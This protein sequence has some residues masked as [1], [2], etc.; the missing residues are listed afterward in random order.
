M[1]ILKIAFKNINSLQGAH[2]VDFRKAPFY[3][4]T[5]FAITGATGSGKSSILDIIVLA[6]FNRTPRFGKISKSE[7]ENNGAILTRG[8]K[9]AY[10]RVTYESNHGEFVSE[11]SISTARTGN[12]RDYEMQVYDALTHTSLVQKKSEVP[13]KNEE[14]IGLKYDQFVKSV[15]LAQGEFAEFLIS[16]KSE[17]TI[18]LEKITGT[19]I[20][21]KLGMKAFEKVRDIKGELDDLE[22]EK[23]NWEKELL[24]E[25]QFNAFKEDKKVLEEK[26]KKIEEEKSHIKSLIELKNNINIAE[27]EYEA[28]LTKEKE[29]DAAFEK[30]KLNEGVKLHRHK[31]I[32]PVQNELIEWN[33]V[34]NEILNLEKQIKENEVESAKE[35]SL[36]D[37]FRYEIKSL[38][39]KSVNEDEYE[40]A[41]SEFEKNVNSLN[42]RYEQK[43]ALG[44]SLKNQISAEI[45]PLNVSFGDANYE[46]VLRKLQKL[47]KEA[48]S[49]LKNHDME[50]L[51]VEQCE[52]EIIILQE[53][54]TTLLQAKND[55]SHILN[56]QVENETLEKEKLKLEGTLIDLPQQITLLEERLKHEKALL[57]NL[58]LKLENQKL[59]ASLEEH[60]HRLKDGEACPLCG[61]IEH[62]FSI[63][64]PKENPSTLEKQISLKKQEVDK[65]NTNYNEQKTTLKLNAQT[66]EK[67]N[68]KINNLNQNLIKLKEI[69]NEK[70]AFELNTPWDEKSQLLKE[71]AEILKLALKHKKE[72]SISEIAIPT[73]EKMLTVLEEATKARKNLRQLYN[74]SL[75]I[76]EKIS[77]ME[78]NWNK[79]KSQQ[80]ILDSKKE[81]LAKDKTQQLQN[82][83]SLVSII[84]NKLSPDEFSSLEMAFSSL[85]KYDDLQRL[86]SQQ[87]KFKEC[88]QEFRIRKESILKQIEQFKLKDVSIPLEDLKAN[89]T[90]QQNLEKIEKK[91]W[92]EIQRK[93]VNQAEYKAKINKIEKRIQ[94]VRKNSQ[95]WILLNELIGDAKGNKFNTFAQDLTLLQLLRLA[96]K[97]LAMLS[98][99][100]IIDNSA[101]G[102]DESLVVIDQD[103]GGVRRTV[104]SLSGGETFILSLA[105][106]LALSDLAS[107]NVQIQSLFIDE[108][109]GTLDPD[110]LDQTLT[111]LEQLQ[112]EGSKMIGI[113]SHVSTLKERISTQ[114][115]IVPNGR[116]FSSV[117]II[118]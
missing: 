89:L 64:L 32:V 55:A 65:L 76:E 14:L 23:I 97:R 40:A 19:D 5:L 86:E 26:I 117:Q 102:E 21:R 93:L 75:P 113:I 61:A 71:K 43:K 30:F 6:L 116:G 81:S 63:H 58:L 57:E 85:L 90:Q 13:D 74:N 111:T 99:R 109:F 25:N 18:L 118:G 101:Q 52:N 68:E 114:I 77:S 95:H 2:E 59:F 82:L 15:M 50:H 47:K 51:D 38:L 53:Q 79:L 48:L 60:R 44:V 103:M 10:A 24:E 8:Q 73:T 88:Q 56:S 1:K 27:L 70:Y 104:K 17:R 36:K 110:T 42:H 37:V 41:L 39:G 67:L 105:L 11:W 107:S 20:Y 4:D 84:E 72:L 92:D 35:K 80:K 9:E 7:I 34:K 49:Y 69:F 83:T 62:P 94:E 100:Y 45:R 28:C 98:Q 12:L 96:N 112:E 54:L 91:T 78:K 31:K 16:K 106:A 3:G 66:L 29:N 87:N 33:R 115:Q 108:G 22:K 46:D